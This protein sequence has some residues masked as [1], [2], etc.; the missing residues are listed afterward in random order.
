MDN[1]YANMV[2]LLARFPGSSSACATFLLPKDI[3]RAHA[4]QA[5]VPCPLSFTVNIMDDKV[6]LN[7]FFRSQDIL[8]LALCDMYFLSKLQER[9]IADLGRLRGVKDECRP[10]PGAMTFF[11]SNAFIRKGHRELAFT[12]SAA[13]T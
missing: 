9:L 10:K 8:N 13:H 1:Q 12:L 3:M 11:V 6:S 7:V 4:I 2:R 5:S